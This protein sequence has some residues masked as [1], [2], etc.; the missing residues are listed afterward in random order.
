ML[1]VDIDPDAAGAAAA[2][3]RDFEGSQVRLGDVMDSDIAELAAEGVDAIFA[4]PARRTGASRGSA[5]ITNPEAWSPPLSAVLR[6]ARTIDRVGVKVAPGIAHDL[7]PADWHAQW[8]SVGGSLVEASLWSPALAPEGRG[9]SC[10]LLDE[11]GAAHSLASPRGEAANAPAERVEVAP[12]G[13]IIAEADPAVIRSGL[14]ARLAQ[15]IGAGIVSDKIA[16]LTGDDVPDSPFYD[17]F[18][19]LEVTNLRPKAIA[20]ALRSRD[21]GAVEIKKRGADINPEDSASIPQ[22]SW[23]NQGTD[24]HCDAPG[25]APP[26]RHLSAVARKPV[27]KLSTGAERRAV[28]MEAISERNAMTLPFGSSQ[29]ST[30]GVEWEL[31]LVDRD[32]HD[33]RQSADAIIDRATIDGQLYPGVHR[34]M[35]LNTIEVVSK[36]RSTV[37]ECIADLTGCVDFLRPLASDLRID[38]AT[39]GTH[40]FARPGRQRVTDSE[41]YAQLVERTAYWGHQMLLYGVHVHVGVEDRAKILPIQA[42]LTAHLGHLQAISAS[43]PFWAGEDTGYASNRAMVFQQ[44]PTAGIPRQF[45]TWEDLEAYTDD[46]IRTGVIEGFDE[47][48]WDI[49]PSPAFGTIEN[50]VYDAATNATEVATFAALT[51][52]LVEHF[53]RLYDAGEPLPV[54]PDWFVAE[55]KWR[56]ARYGMDATLI[57]SRD[58]TTESARD[59]IARLREELAPVAADLG[60][61][62]EFAGLDT[63]LTIGAS[64]ERQRSVAAAARPGQGLDAVVDLMRAE[65]SAGRPLALAEFATLSV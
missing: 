15:R 35:L 12:L 60:C 8:V 3:L 50:R 11:T 6:L 14:L 46:M 48:R 31:Q 9:R 22:A 21:A 27:R 56:S 33:L 65:M 57:V 18:E 54:L 36:P 34:E 44:L 16:Y 25:G 47:V 64:Y 17:R 55:N 30:I 32:S 61:A 62:R 13:A 45:D 49:R 43:S 63:I 29:R 1:A 51:H 42:A 59:G 39:A 5:R 52:V 19:V 40:P 4:D 53:S 20:A 24:S 7:I 58:G 41:R 10:L 38:L 2:N 37:A 26:G 23:R 28:T